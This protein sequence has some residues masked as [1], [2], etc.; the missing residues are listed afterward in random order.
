MHRGFG[1]GVGRRRLRLVLCPLG[2]G[3]C[4][5]AMALVVIFYGAPYNPLWWWAMA[6]V[7]AAATMA[8]LAVVP[9]VE[10]VI[11]GYLDDLGGHDRPAAAEDPQP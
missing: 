9:V 7:L 4:A 1:Q 10:W 5:G 3:L 11:A 6:G 8:P 2:G